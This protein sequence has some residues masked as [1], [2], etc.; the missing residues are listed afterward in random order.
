[1]PHRA[2]VSFAIPIH[3][4][5]VSEVDCR[6]NF[7]LSSIIM[8][9]QW[10]RI[11]LTSRIGEGCWG[12]RPS[13]AL[14][15]LI[16]VQFRFDWPVQNDPITN[17]VLC[18][19]LPSSKDMPKIAFSIHPAEKCR[20]YGSFA[21]G[22]QTT[23]HTFRPTFGCEQL[24]Q[25]DQRRTRTRRVRANIMCAHIRCMCTRCILYVRPKQLHRV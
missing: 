24:V 7:R 13:N 20:V 12:R 9:I 21:D 6:S 3:R 16:D 5:N 2:R 4:Q 18:M 22:T 1:M 15:V 11:S 10:P 23:M 14:S 8:L 19:N 25:F 17:Y